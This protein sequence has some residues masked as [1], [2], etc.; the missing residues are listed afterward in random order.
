MLNVFHFIKKL[1]GNFFLTNQAIL[2]A[3][4]FLI[5]ELMSERIRKFP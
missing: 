4:Q 2:N 1:Q 5:I 3:L